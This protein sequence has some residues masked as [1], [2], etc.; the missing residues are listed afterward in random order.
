MT[1]QGASPVIEDVTVLA[2]CLRDVS[3]IPEALRVFEQVGRERVEE[4]ARSGSNGSNPAHL[5]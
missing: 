5:R 4:I 2:R 3:P 1:P